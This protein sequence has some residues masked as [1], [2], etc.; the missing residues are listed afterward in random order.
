MGGRALPERLLCLL[1][2]CPPSF[3][4]AIGALALPFVLS[5]YKNLVL[6]A[7]A[8]ESGGRQVPSEPHCTAGWSPEL[9]PG[10]LGEGGHWAPTGPSL[11]SE[12]LGAMPGIWKVALN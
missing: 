8:R 12:A 3:S 1:L 2:F 6:E 5:F 7:G 9:A 10:F 4:K 11:A